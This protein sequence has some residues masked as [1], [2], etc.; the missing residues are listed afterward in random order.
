MPMK[1]LYECDLCGQEIAATANDPVVML[2]SGR[3]HY[4]CMGER[5]RRKEEKQHEKETARLIAKADARDRRLLLSG[6]LPFASP[7]TNDDEDE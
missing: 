2:S 1:G 7:S 6:K 5:E 4:R 3:F